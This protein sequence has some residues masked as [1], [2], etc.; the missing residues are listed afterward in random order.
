MRILENFLLKQKK[1]GKR[2]VS[3]EAALQLVCGKDKEM[4]EALRNTV[5]PNA[6]SPF[7]PLQEL[8]EKANENR[9]AGDKHHEKIWTLL[10][11]RHF[12]YL[13]D[14]ENVK[15][16]FGRYEEL[17]GKRLVILRGLEEQSGR[18]IKKIFSKTK[19]QGGDITERALNRAQ[20]YYEFI[21]AK[22]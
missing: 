14:L 16:W 15:D 7:L 5:L 22:K 17:T 9:D 3:P 19:K 11:A 12:L 21:G 2:N 4:Y 20:E 13:G 18:D 6:P 1:R 10:V 8:I